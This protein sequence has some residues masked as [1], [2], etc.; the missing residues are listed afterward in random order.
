MTTVKRTLSYAVVSACS[1]TCPATSSSS[2]C[3]S[4]TAL[5]RTHTF[6][7]THIVTW[8]MSFLISLPQTPKNIGMLF[9]KKYVAV[10]IYYRADQTYNVSLS[11]YVKN[12]KEHKLV[13]VCGSHTALIRT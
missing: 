9:L 5:I 8:M 13:A 1:S 6:W 10:Y 3:G 7:P 11:L 2:A 12:S 4:R